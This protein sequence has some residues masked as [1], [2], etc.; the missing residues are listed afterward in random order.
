MSSIAC[1][2]KA[3][4]IGDKIR[5]RK[6]LDFAFTKEQAVVI[7]LD[8]NRFMYKYK[9]QVMKC[10]KR[11]GKSKIGRTVRRTY[12]PKKTSSGVP[13]T[14][15]LVSDE[16]G[17]VS[18]ISTDISTTCN[19][20]RSLARSKKQVQTLKVDNTKNASKIKILTEKLHEMNQAFIKEKKATNAIIASSRKESA[21]VLEI[22]K[23]LIQQSKHLKRDAEEMKAKEKVDMTKL[24]RIE[25]INYSKK[26]K[27][28]KES[29][30]REKRGKKNS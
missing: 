1:E 28:A 10:H 3:T 21:E 2:G 15:T 24:A 29:F 16:K 9:N 11:K 26:L 5:S 14:I 13:S 23:S 8:G 17:T 27:V 18:S 19:I 4:V 25:R 22:A 7:I 30:L 20:K 12:K 6:R